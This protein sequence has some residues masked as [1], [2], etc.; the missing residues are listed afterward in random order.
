MSIQQ[1]DVKVQYLYDTGAIRKLDIFAPFIDFLSSLWTILS[2]FQIMLLS[3]RSGIHSIQPATLAVRIPNLWSTQILTL[4]F[5]G[6][7][8]EVHRA[9]LRTAL[10]REVPET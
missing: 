1:N 6:I 5:Q 8:L 4:V 2:S 9:N 3:F 7:A 10:Q